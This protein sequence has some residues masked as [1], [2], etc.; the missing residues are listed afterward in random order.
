VNHS[1][2]T[3][4]ST[5]F[6]DPSKITCC[7]PGSVF[8]AST[9]HYKLDLWSCFL[10]MNDQHLPISYINVSKCN[11]FI[12]SIKLPDKLVHFNDKCCIFYVFNN[13]KSIRIPVIFNC[14]CIYFSPFM[15]FKFRCNLSSFLTS[16][17]FFI[18]F[19]F[20]T[21]TNLTWTYECSTFL[22]AS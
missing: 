22:N 18:N 8:H 6:T 12:I 21:F 4:V 20:K 11:C 3:C 5:H 2:T 9:N 14:I 19:F 7:K 16:I 1:F 13:I 17:A 15:S 10:C